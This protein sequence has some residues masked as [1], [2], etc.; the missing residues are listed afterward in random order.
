MYKS[1]Y[2]CIWKTLNPKPWALNFTDTV[3]GAVWLCQIVKDLLRFVLEHVEDK[4]VIPLLEVIMQDMWTFVFFP[5]FMHWPGVGGNWN[6]NWIIMVW[7][8]IYWSHSVGSVGGT[9][10]TAANAS[11]TPWSVAGY[12]FLGSSTG[13]NSSNS[14]GERPGEPVKCRA[15]GMIYRECFLLRVAFY[16]RVF[17]QSCLFWLTQVSVVFVLYTTFFSLLSVEGAIFWN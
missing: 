3:H 2:C 9:K 4:E 17:P 16:D 7:N 12:C 5:F 11:K 10:G 8:K 6:L 15:F 1:I 13:L 14:C